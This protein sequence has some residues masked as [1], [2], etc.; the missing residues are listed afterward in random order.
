MAREPARTPYEAEQRYIRIISRSLT[1]IT[2]AIWVATH[3][4]RGTDEDRTLFVT[5]AS[6]GSPIQ[7]KRAGGPPVHLTAYQMFRLMPDTRWAA[8]EWKASSRQYGY[9][10]WES[11]SDHQ[12]K[13]VIQWHWH[14]G[15]G[16][17]DEPHV[18][19]RAAEEMFG[20]STRRLHIPTERVSFEAVVRFL[21]VDL[22]VT[23]LRDDWQGLIDEALA[24]F[25]RFRTWPRSAP[26]PTANEP[27]S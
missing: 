3:P 7:L 14:P 19:V 10:V 18:H 17:T 27:V 24:S 26:I 22:G 20:R 11:T 23:P 5:R 8:D 13:P 4:L 6:D 21:I 2:K 9:G 16:N 15:S 1:C 25:V 12:L